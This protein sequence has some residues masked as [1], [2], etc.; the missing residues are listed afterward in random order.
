MKIKWKSWN[1]IKKHDFSMIFVFPVVFVAGQCPV[2]HFLP[3]VGPFP[4]SR[5]TPP[6]LPPFPPLAPTPGSPHQHLHP[7]PHRATYWNYFGVWKS[8]MQKT[9][10]GFRDPSNHHDM[11]MCLPCTIWQFACIAALLHLEN[12]SKRTV[13]ELENIRTFSKS[14]TSYL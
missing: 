10:V 2:P 1:S 9:G 12:L 5:A 8:L 11:E 6:H 3:L 14:S 7:T 4:R 13:A